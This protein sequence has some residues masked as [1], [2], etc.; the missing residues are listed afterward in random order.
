M[1]PQG[2]SI[3]K[4]KCLNEKNRAKDLSC[5]SSIVYLWWLNVTGLVAPTVYAK[6]L[7][8]NLPFFFS[9]A[10]YCAKKRSTTS[11]SGWLLPS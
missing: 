5:I 6:Y 2:K 10:K 1:I 3:L 7:A 9:K 8:K 11:K 4:K